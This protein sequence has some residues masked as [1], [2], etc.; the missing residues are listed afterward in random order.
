[1]GFIICEIHGGNEAGLISEYHAEKINKM[2]ESIDSEILNI[3]VFDKKGLF[4][5]RYIVDPTLVNEIGIKES[6]LTWNRNLKNMN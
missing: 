3:E 2:E 4:N 1:M 5:G 6:K